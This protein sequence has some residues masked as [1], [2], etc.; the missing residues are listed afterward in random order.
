MDITRKEKNDLKSY[1]LFILKWQ[2]TWSSRETFTAYE[3]KTG[4]GIAI[5]R[6]WHIKK[7][8]P[9]KQKWRPQDL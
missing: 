2:E 7:S 5:L 9:N 1:Y 3:K 8:L 6:R 4:K